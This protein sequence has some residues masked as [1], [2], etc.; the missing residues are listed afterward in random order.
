MQYYAI[1]VYT[2]DEDEFSKLFVQRTNENKLYIPKRAINERRRGKIVHRISPLFPGYVFVESENLL[3]DLD[4]YWTLRTTKGFIRFLGD[5]KKPTPISEKDLSLL[6]HFIS[7]GEV[8]DT[9]RVTFDENDRIVVI[10][11]PLKGLEGQIERVDK[12]KGRAR[13]SLEMCNSSFHIYLGF[14]IIERVS[15]EGGYDYAGSRT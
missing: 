2:G 15:T 4:L 9:S 3:G 13:I 1:Q 12:R 5:N 6:R 14:E 7:F 11:G 8:A 10:E